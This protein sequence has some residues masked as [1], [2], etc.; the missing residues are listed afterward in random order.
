MGIPQLSEGIAIPTQSSPAAKK[1]NKQ[2]NKQQQTNNNFPL[3]L[4]LRFSLG[5]SMTLGQHTAKCASVSS[6]NRGDRLRAHPARRL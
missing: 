3:D 5:V 4:N 1:A 2:T 6:W